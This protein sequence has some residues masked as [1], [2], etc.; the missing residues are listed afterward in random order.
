MK[1]RRSG[2]ILVSAASAIVRARA[3]SADTSVRNHTRTLPVRFS[4]QLQSRLNA[5]QRSVDGRFACT[6]AG[7][8]QLPVY[9]GGT[10]KGKSAAWVAGEYEFHSAW[11]SSR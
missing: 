11:T 7:V 3:A 5:P 10:R 9:A 8:A 1:P 6:P 4:T 2:Q